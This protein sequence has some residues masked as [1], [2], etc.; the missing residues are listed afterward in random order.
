MEKMEE[1]R[2]QEVKRRDLVSG[3]DRVVRL[4]LPIILESR[5]L[6]SF[7]DSLRDL[8][9]LRD[10]GSVTF[11]LEAL[12]RAARSAGPAKD[13]VLLCGEAALAAVR[14]DAGRFA[15]LI[16]D[17]AESLRGATPGLGLHN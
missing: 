4:M 6:M 12:G 15:S 9:T 13:A 1:R 14:G 11:A 10:I 7:A 8:P 16:R 2:R 5:G 17:A 3:A